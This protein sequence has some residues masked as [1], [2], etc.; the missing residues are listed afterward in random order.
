MRLNWWAFERTPKHYC[1]I[2]EAEAERDPM[3][4]RSLSITANFDD[5]H[6]RLQQFEQLESLKFYLCPHGR[7]SSETRIEVSLE[8][9]AE[10]LELRRL[11]EFIILNTPIRQFP[12]WLAPLPKL[13]TLRV[14]GTEV[15]EIPADIELFSRLQELELGNNDISQLPVEIAQL[16]RLKYLGLHSTL[17]VEIPPTILQMPKLRAL[18]LTGTNLSAET[19]AR[20]KRRFPGISLPTEN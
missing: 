19:I 4:V 12:V 14:R 5:V 2:E 9:Q 6:G 13:E 10:V 7:Y 15:R 20:V 11:K 16:H 1:S 8:L 3:K 18:Q 17:I